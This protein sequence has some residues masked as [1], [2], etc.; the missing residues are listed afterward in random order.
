MGTLTV[1]ALEA[2]KLP[3]G[4]KED[5]LHDGNNLSVRLRATKAGVSKAWQFT[6]RFADRREK[7]HIGSYPS[8][9][10]AKAR[11]IAESYRELLSRGVDPKRHVAKEKAKQLAEHL[12]T[13]RGEIPVTVEQL[14][15]RWK[16]DYLAR[17][18][19]D[20][21]AYVHGVF[22][23]HVFPDAGDLH[24]DTLR[25]RHI[26]ALLDK[27]HTDHGLTRTCGVILANL[28]Q[29]FVWAC[30]FDWMMGDPTA[31]L[32]SED[33]NGFGEES[34]R[35]LSDKEVIELYCKIPVSTLPKRWEHATWLVMATMTRSEET[36][37]AQRKHVDL[38]NNTWLIPKENQKSTRRKTPPQDHIVYLSPFAKKHMEALMAFPDTED[39]IFPRSRSKRDKPEPCNKKNHYH[40]IHDRQVGGEPIKGRAKDTASLQLAGGPWAVHDLRRTGSTLMGELE[41]EYSVVERCLNHSIRDK[42]QRTYIRSKLFMPMKEAWLALGSKLEELHAE[43]EKEL[44]KQRAEKPLTAAIA[45]TEGE[46]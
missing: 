7:V 33:W 24:L 13:S 31:G 42:I 44:K 16:T 32:K 18:H 29:M 3:E 2:A 35:A 12:A 45:A 25:P 27:A 23:R 14:F 17:K 36:L 5:W 20:G 4:K 9:T 41:I 1:K 11:E 26:K 39:Y 15:E 43:G 28:R 6:Y 10:L 34:E 38:E 37:L 21:G 8:I 30:T 22:R 19:E 46:I 40:S